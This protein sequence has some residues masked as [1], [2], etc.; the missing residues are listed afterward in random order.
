MCSSFSDFFDAFDSFSCFGADFDLRLECVL[1][2]RALS[3]PS[4]VLSSDECLENSG[5]SGG[6]GIYGAEG[7]TAYGEWEG[8][9]CGEK[10]KFGY[11]D[12]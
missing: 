8:W 9:A 12:G 4:D 11:R 3:S 1:M 2:L 5:F 10:N 7:D 6:G